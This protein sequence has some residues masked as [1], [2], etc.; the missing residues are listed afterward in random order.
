MTVLIQGWFFRKPT[1]LR[2][3]IHITFCLLE[4]TGVNSKEARETKRRPKRLGFRDS[5]DPSAHQ[6]QWKAE[7]PGQAG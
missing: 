7:T 1:I 2:I 6:C 5:P 4:A 3:K